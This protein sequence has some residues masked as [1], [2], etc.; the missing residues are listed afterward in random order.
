MNAGLLPAAV[1][2]LLPGQPAPAAHT[3]ACSGQKM[4]NHADVQYSAIARDEPGSSCHTQPAD[5]IKRCSSQLQLQQQG[6]P[7]TSVSALSSVCNH[8]P[9]LGAVAAI[10]GVKQAQCAHV[11][12]SH[13]IA[14][15][16]AQP[17]ATS[18]RG[19]ALVA[20]SIVGWPQSLA[21]IHT[22][23]CHADVLPSHPPTTIAAIHRPLLVCARSQRTQPFM[24]LGMEQRGGRGWKGTHTHHNAAVAVTGRRKQKDTAGAALA[25]TKP[26]LEMCPYAS[27]SEKVY[28][29]LHHCVCACCGP[30]RRERG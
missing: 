15:G 26:Q 25:L 6:V 1:H 9:R 19:I 16:V 10:R 2:A 28:S 14:L 4:Q 22:H 3:H 5:P 11:H 20:G 23:T 8:S 12:I 18:S 24:Q 7:C 27:C 29:G 17:D 21:H 30:D 13:H